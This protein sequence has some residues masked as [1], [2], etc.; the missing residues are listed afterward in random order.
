MLC[1]EIT[2]HT[3]HVVFSNILWERIWIWETYYLTS[4]QE[5]RFKKLFLNFMSPAIQFV[6]IGWAIL[7]F[8][9]ENTI[10][11][12]P[13]ENVAKIILLFWSTIV[14]FRNGILFNSYGCGSFLTVPHSIG[15]IFVN[16]F[17]CMWSYLDNVI[18]NFSV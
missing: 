8:K 17:V 4:P 18:T 10:K 5:D 16:F 13:F 12:K 2:S 7:K 1:T 6:N 11:L 15:T 3:V 9:F 14:P